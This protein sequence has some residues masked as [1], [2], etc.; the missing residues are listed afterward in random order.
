MVNIDEKHVVKKYLTLKQA[1][2]YCG[3]AYS[4]ARKRWPGWGIPVYKLGRGPLFEVAELDR[5]IKRHR[6]N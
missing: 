6:I 4:T 5:M 2:E 3:M 1:A